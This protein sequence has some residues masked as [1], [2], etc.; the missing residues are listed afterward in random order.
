MQESSVVNVP[1]Y[2]VFGSSYPS[3]PGLRV[4]LTLVPAA[5][6]SEVLAAYHLPAPGGG[7]APAPSPAPAA[8]ATAGRRLLQ[9]PPP[10]PAPPTNVT[11][12]AT[13][14][15]YLGDYAAE[16]PDA[17]SFETAGA[18]QVGVGTA[19]LNRCVCDSHFQK[20]RAEAAVCNR[21]RKKRVLSCA[22]CGA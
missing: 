19:N 15:T 11:N 6:E 12:R 18:P 8:N 3:D 20:Q 14:W 7:A 2:D 22:C 16:P 10:V 1:A 21:R 17:W 9:A 5:L 4:R 13:G